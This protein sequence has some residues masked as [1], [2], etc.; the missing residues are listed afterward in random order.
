MKLAEALVRVKDL[1]GKF[2]E[3]QQV[4][5]SDATFE[6]VDPDMEIPSIEDQLNELVSVSEEIASMKSRI[7][8]TN[9]E[10]GLSIKIHTMEHLRSCV[11]K[12]EDLT[13]HKQIRV[14]LR[15]IDYNSPAIKLATHA[16]Y[17]VAKWTET[18]NGYRA[19]IREL[20]LELQRLNWEV[21]LVD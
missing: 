17:N 1:K 15:S 14:N 20:D 21:D 10:R 5:Y 19:R 4:V 12:L 2:A 18:V 6:V 7:T 8:R 3:L 9:A 16:T 11:S 13:R